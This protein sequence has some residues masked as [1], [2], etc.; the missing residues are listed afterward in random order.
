MNVVI[1]KS[2][3]QGKGAFAAKDFAKGEVVLRWRPKPLDAGDIKQIS[4]KD[5]KYVVK[6][7]NEYFLQQAPERYVNQSCDP[8]TFAKDECDIALRDIKAGEEITTDYG[9]SDFE[10]FICNC[11][12]CKE[13]KL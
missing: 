11:P 6:I 2:K 9:D 4:K 1:K 10:K 8:N 13:I 3:I 12:R 7:G 5:L